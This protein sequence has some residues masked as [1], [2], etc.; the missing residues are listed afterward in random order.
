MPPFRYIE[1]LLSVFYGRA[2]TYDQSC[3]QNRKILDHDRGK[4]FQKRLKAAVLKK[5]K[6]V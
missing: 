1:L 2:Q 3:V 6:E 5:L 4:N